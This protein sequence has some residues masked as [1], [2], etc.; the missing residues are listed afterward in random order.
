MDT[1]PNPTLDLIECSTTKQH[2]RN[3]PEEYCVLAT[4]FNRN[5]YLTLL[6]DSNGN[7][8]IVTSLIHGLALVANWSFMWICEFVCVCVCAMIK[9]IDLGHNYAPTKITMTTDHLCGVR[10][11][12]CSDCS[13]WMWVREWV[14]EYEWITHT[15]C[16]YP[17]PCPCP[18]PPLLL[19][20]VPLSLF[21]SS[22]SCN[23]LF[24]LPLLSLFSLISLCVFVCSLFSLP[25]LFPC[26]IW[27]FHPLIP[28]QTH[29]LSYSPVFVFVSLFL[30]LCFVCVT[31]LCLF[32]LSLSL[33]LSVS[34]SFSH[35]L[36]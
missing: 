32:S 24:F 25:P 27:L 2:S 9:P 15:P 19:S 12:E 29:S 16:P 35:G 11:N 34:A 36:A 10:F 5:P 6:L 1:L 21:P 8:A 26:F 14:S 22:L 30:S 3:M 7:I 18:R 33:S 23:P 28:T 20:N 13:V 31:K 4:L 17:Y